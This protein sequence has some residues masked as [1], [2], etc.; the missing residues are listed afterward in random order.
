M[1]PGTLPDEQPHPSTNEHDENWDEDISSTGPTGLLIESILWNGMQI[2]NQLRIWQRQEQPIS[3]L[4]TPYQNLK[5]SI[6]K[7]AGRARN[8]AEWHR[9]VSN[10]RARAPVEIDNDISRIA[11]CLDEESKGIL[12]VVQM[13]GSQALEHIAG[14][15]EDIGAVRTYCNKAT[16]TSDHK[17]W[18]CEYFKSVRTEIDEELANIPHQMIPCCL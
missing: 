4:E 17:R 3:I 12:R 1:V 10:K 6:L 11:P 9:G 5:T 15:N 7:A 14:Y 13:G 18:E 16:S 2:D 8:R